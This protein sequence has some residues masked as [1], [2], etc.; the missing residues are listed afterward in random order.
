MIKFM[1]KNILAVF[2]LVC[3]IAVMGCGNKNEA[4]DNKDAS[5]QTAEAEKAEDNAGDGTEA[6]EETKKD[7]SVDAISGE[8]LNNI[9]YVDDLSLLDAEVASMFIDFGS[10]DIV[11]SAVYESSGAT[12]EEIIVVECS[13]D[14]DAKSVKKSLE[15]R[16]EEQKISY[17][18][19]V[20]EELV[21]LNKAVI[22]QSGNYA[23]LS[24]SDEPEKA[25]EIIGSYL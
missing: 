20:P 24:V 4:A 17:E 10:A 3:M 2:G 7:A 23:I 21:K 12:A 18:D 11:N 13:S 15:S 22:V 16:V 5:T 25:E 19:Y 14:A 8:L 6:V 1:K 9:S